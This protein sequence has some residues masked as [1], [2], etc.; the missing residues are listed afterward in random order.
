[1]IRLARAYISSHSCRVRSPKS[2]KWRIFFLLLCF[3]PD[4]LPQ[5]APF[6]KYKLTE[7]IHF[8]PCISPRRVV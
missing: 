8:L 1:M 7:S 3:L 6:R 2:I 5:S 4:I